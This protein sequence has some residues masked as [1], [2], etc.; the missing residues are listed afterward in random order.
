MTLTKKTYEVVSRA[1]RDVHCPGSA[2][3]ATKRA[4]VRSLCL[5]FATN[6]PRFV[7]EQF[8]VA[9]YGPSDVEYEEAAGL[10]TELG[11]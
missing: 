7:I 1:L 11:A 2:E 5:E 3:L 4:I 6:N 9:C 8:V 10:C